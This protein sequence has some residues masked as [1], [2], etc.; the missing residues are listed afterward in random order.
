[1][2]VF[3]ISDVQYIF[4][5]KSILISRYHQFIEIIVVAK[6]HFSVGIENNAENENYLFKG[7]ILDFF[8]HFSRILNYHRY[9]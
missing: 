8:L 4:N 9:I 1:M 3:K 2:C 6:A 5:I 7:S